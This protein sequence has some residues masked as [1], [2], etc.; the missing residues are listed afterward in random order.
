MAAAKIQSQINSLPADI[1]AKITSGELFPQYSTSQIRQGREVE[2]G[3]SELTGFTSNGPDGSYYTYDLSGKQ[4]GQ[5]ERQGGGG[6]F[7]GGILN[8]IGSGVSDFISDPSKA[9]TQFFENPGVK[10]AATVAAMYYGIPMLTEAAGLGAAGAAGTLGAAEGALT[11]SQIAGLPGLAGAAGATT[12]ALTPAALES[13]I[14][15]AGYGASAAAGA[16]SGAGAYLAGLGATGA[17]LG[18]EGALAG[19]ATSGGLTAA[20][21]A[22]AD[23]AAYPTSGIVG[24]IPAEAGLGSLASTIT[25]ASVVAAET[26]PTASE[27][28]ASELT[29]YPTSGIAGTIPAEAGLGS[30]TTAPVTVGATEGALASELATVP[31]VTQGGL[32]TT[33]ATVA[34]EGIA[35]LAGT[36]A[37][38]GALAS[39]SGLSATGFGTGTTAAGM[40]GT[41]L[42]A[43]T[44]A[45]TLA[46]DALAAEALGS[47][48]S[49]SAN[50]IGAGLA[51][52]GAGEVAGL[53][54]GTSLAPA[55][56]AAEGMGGAG[57]SATTG[58]G[59]LGGDALA[60]QALA[61]EG[62]GGGA[63]LTAATGTGVAAGDALAAGTAGAAGMGGGTGLT[64]G[65]T[66]ATDG[67]ASLGTNSSLT[68]A[69]KVASGTTS[70][71]TL[72]TAVGNEAVASG[73]FTPGSVGSVANAAGVLTPT[74]LAAAAGSAGLGSLTGADAAAANLAASSKEAVASGLGPGSVG[75]AQAGTL[76]AA[77]LAA[78]AG[79]N[80]GGIDLLDAAKKAKQAKDLLDKK[81][82]TAAV[83]GTL[84]LAALLAS[85]NKGKATDNN[86]YTGTVPTYSAARQQ[87]PVSQ[88]RPGSAA[89]PYRPGQ[90]GIT[91]FTP[92]N[93]NR[94]ADPVAESAVEPEFKAAVM[95][96]YGYAPRKLDSEV[97]MAEGGQVSAGLPTEGN[98]SMNYPS[99]EGGYGYGGEGAIGQGGLAPQGAL[100]QFAGLGSLGGNPLMA[101]GMNQ[102]GI[103]GLY[104][105]ANSPP[106]QYTTGGH[107]L[108][109]SMQDQP[110]VGMAHGG[111]VPGQYN[112]GSYSDGGRLLKGP[113]DGVSDSIPA[114]IGRKQPA[115]LATGEFVIPARIV[116]ELG[117]GSTEAGAKR[118]YEMM[119]RV[120]QTRRKTKNVAANTNAAKYLPA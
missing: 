75:A 23:L 116:S 114:I 80:T 111:A 78:A 51:S 117:N 35:S 110:N 119:K 56:L 89:A 3:P 72:N 31:A 85:M 28:L 32:A 12:A 34:P 96:D 49:V 98:Q 87:L 88:T 59:A 14:G 109:P 52:L 16:G 100:P 91:Y 112:L 108:D 79:T 63:G 39:G 2:E 24:A 90:G 55:S 99:R 6:G 94:T 93:Y 62:M 86:T 97:L 29:A 64:S 26:L 50:P 10:E 71:G 38:E 106:P 70:G 107:S 53:G 65:L 41:G 20:E 68:A 95:P 83:G 115:R 15:T 54:L 57:L 73:T 67:I 17:T 4:T 104:G 43:A 60:T 40:G 36:G 74:Q 9:T 13:L 77:E 101:Q 105:G 120:Q 81:N 8:K 42:T 18:A 27:L 21:I 84:G 113:G 7:L 22:A 37:T 102:G 25:P 66:S 47:G 30:L 44:G 103:N 1:Q 118:L 61:A 48:L 69:D 46:G 5:V 45:G 76:T 58:A 82:K 19:G 33:A 11:A 92:V